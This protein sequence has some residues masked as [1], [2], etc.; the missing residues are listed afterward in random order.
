MEF[1]QQNM[2]WVGLA[3]V[4]GGMLIWPLIAG[5]TVASLTPAEATLMMN[6][7]D[8]VVLDVRE[9]GEWGGGHIGGARHITLGQLDKRL[10][11]LDKFK[12][13]PIIVVCASGNR[14]SSACG[15]LKK[16]GFGK[17]FSLGGGVS[18]WRDANLPLTTKS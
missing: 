18:S 3:V 10:S 12:D 5:G 9:T 6:R 7:E 16:H 8:A 15:Q 1:L 17:V 11:E 14:S 13:K 4:S 2:I